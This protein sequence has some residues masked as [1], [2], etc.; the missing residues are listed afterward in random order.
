MNALEE[1]M[2]DRPVD[3]KDLNFRYFIFKDA[4]NNQKCYNLTYNDPCLAVPLLL[5]L[6][7]NDK[8]QAI[9]QKVW[10][11]TIWQTVRKNIERRPVLDTN[12]CYHAASLED[13]QNSLDKGHC[14]WKN[15]D[16]YVIDLSKLELFDLTDSDVLKKA[17]NS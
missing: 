13:L 11:S 12:G 15:G 2:N 10:T 9:A 7:D 16:P 8:A 1:I 5:A 6:N 3:V 14:G 4:V 17:C